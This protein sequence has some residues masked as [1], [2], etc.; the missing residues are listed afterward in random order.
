MAV[1]KS[2]NRNQPNKKP[3]LVLSTYRYTV[4]TV[5]LTLGGLFLL[6]QVAKAQD[7]KTLEGRVLNMSGDALK[8]SSLT[9]NTPSLNQTT[10]DNNGYYR[11]DVTDFPTGVKLDNYDRGVLQPGAIKVEFFDLI[12]RNI[13]RKDGYLNSYGEVE[14]I[15]FDGSKLKDGNMYIQRITDKTGNAVSK[16]IIGG[17][18]APLQKTNIEAMIRN[19]LKSG[20][21][22]LADTFAYKITVKDKEAVKRFNDET[23]NVNGFNKTDFYHYQDLVVNEFV[24]KNGE[25]KE[26]LFNSQPV[27]I[28]ITGLFSNDNEILYSSNSKNISFK[29]QN[30][31]ILMTYTPSGLLNESITISAKDELDQ[32]ISQEIIFKA[33]KGRA[34]VG[35]ARD[36]E[37][38]KP[39]DSV[40][41]RAFDG[42][43]TYY[44]YSDNLGN[45]EVLV[46]N[47][48]NYDIYMNKKGFTEALNKYKVKGDVTVFKRNNL[49]PE[50][51]TRDSRFMAIFTD[52]CHYSGTNGGLSANFFFDD[53][54]TSTYNIYINKMTDYLTY[55]PKVEK[56]WIQ[57]VKDGIWKDTLLTD[58]VVT[59]KRFNIVEIN[60]VSEVDKS[61]PFTHIYFKDDEN[62]GR[63]Y[64]IDP[65]TGIMDYLGISIM[66]GLNPDLN[67][68]IKAINYVANIEFLSGYIRDPFDGDKFP[69]GSDWPD[70]QSYFGYN[71]GPDVFTP[72]DTILMRVRFDELLNVNAYGN[73]P[74]INFSKLPA[75]SEDIL[76]SAFI[77]IK[78]ELDY[79]AIEKNKI[80]Y[81]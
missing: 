57:A 45:F 25:L 65:Q 52:I 78:T 74:R 43:N 13:A 58:G 51:F 49:Y 33:T 67:N 29:K 5:G 70:A 80:K 10:S 1:S 73:H 34:I 81:N 4:K 31:N 61:K 48:G 24:T 3:I 66:P 64:T 50:V 40:L 42:Q 22:T 76:K 38:G 2:Y 32:S 55:Y 17:D 19:N 7:T 8:N 11:F 37:W 62:S 12:G 53:D 68:Q 15:D 28:D 16:K 18:Y 63:G 6:G 9:L 21:E 27:T 39:I 69:D 60:S 47:E 26:L 71:G 35:H 36:L 75:P 46:Q 54:D 14:D 44:A 79:S 59:K 72:L 30:E 20:S 56:E 77:G 23:V 41:V